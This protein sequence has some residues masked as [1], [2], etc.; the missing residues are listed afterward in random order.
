M[1]WYGGSSRTY[2]SVVAVGLGWYARVF[3]P[4]CVIHGIN[5]SVDCTIIAAMGVEQD[6]P[7]FSNVVERYLL[8]CKQLV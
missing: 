4:A 1:L 2:T 8:V 7:T 3:V 6:I 5:V